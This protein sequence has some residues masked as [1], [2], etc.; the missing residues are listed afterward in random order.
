MMDGAERLNR[1]LS[2]P[3][4]RGSWGEIQLEVALEAAGLVKGLHFET[5]FTTKSNDSLLRPDAV[6]KLSNDR[7]LVVDSKLSL[8]DFVSAQAATDDEDRRRYLERHAS[9]VKRHIEQLSKKEYRDAVEG[10]DFVVM[11]VPAESIYFAAFEMDR[12]LIQYAQ[13][14]NVIL[15]NP[16]TLLTIFQCV[17][18]LNRLAK[19]SEESEQIRK[20]ATELCDR[21]GTFGGHFLKVGSGLRQAMENYN[22][23]ATSFESQLFTSAQ[24]IQELGIRAKA[25]DVPTEIEIEVREFV[26]VDLLRSIEEARDVNELPEPQEPECELPEA[27]LED[28]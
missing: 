23:S 5:Q 3:H 4:V 6:I 28:D 21:L 24:R 15:A 14:R 13:E 2:K 22:R 12:N 9:S 25:T 10:V 11:F 1:A 27:L 19:A 8:E 18:Q 16:M 20:L 17:A 26:K 7:K